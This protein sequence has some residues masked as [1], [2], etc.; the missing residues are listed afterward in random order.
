M[1]VTAE[2]GG[3]PARPT[4]GM[5]AIEAISS[6][7]KELTSTVVHTRIWMAIGVNDV[8]SRYRRTLL[9]PLWIVLAQF[10]IITGLYLLRHT[11]A[12]VEMGNYYLFLSSGLPIWGLIAS[13]TSDGTN[14]L[15]RSKGMIESYPLPMMIYV[16]RSIVQN[17]ITFLHTILVFVIVCVFNQYMPP[18]S[19]LLIVPALVIVAIYGFGMHLL[20]APLCARYK[21]LSPAIAS[22]MTVAY[23]MSP[24]FW[25]VLPE[26][27][28]LVL[29]RFNPFYYLIEI[30]RAPLLGEPPALS[31]WIKAMGIAVGAFVAGVL[32]YS[33]YRRRLVF[34]I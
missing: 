3:A 31:F 22:V 6:A 29:V 14:A 1:T 18:L 12:R 27:A 17:Y 5:G 11:I 9:G 33:R 24:V 32:V 30:V 4:G 21:D 13:L 19:A 2:R 25:P 28:G 16:M 7:L 20:V 10:A 34:W 23:V 8:A 15:T 26:Q